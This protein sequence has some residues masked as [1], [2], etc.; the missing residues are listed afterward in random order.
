MTCVIYKGYQGSVS[1]EDDHLV[2]RILHIDDL[3]STVFDKAS[4]AKAVFKDLVDDYLETCAEIGKEPC[5]PHK[6]SFNVRMAP[7]I[8]RRAAMLAVETNETLNAWVVRAIEKQIEAESSRASVDPSALMHFAAEIF[9]ARNQVGNWHP[10]PQRLR[11]AAEISIATHP[12]D[13]LRH[14]ARRLPVHG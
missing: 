10:G 12:A 2:V 1:F 4:E 3:I 6:G 11:G 13:H 14:F 8:H 9:S 5:K 7:E